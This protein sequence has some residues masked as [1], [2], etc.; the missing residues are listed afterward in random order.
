MRLIFSCWT[1]YLQKNK[2]FSRSNWFYF[3][4]KTVS[5]SSIYCFPRYI[6]IRN[7]YKAIPK[8]PRLGQN[9][10][11]QFIF[12]EGRGNYNNCRIV[13]IGLRTFWSP[14]DWR[15]YLKHDLCGN[16]LTQNKILKLDLPIYVIR[17]IIPNFIF[18]PFSSDTFFVDTRVQAYTIRCIRLVANPGAYL[19]PVA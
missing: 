11:L 16:R 18:P 7:Y 3:L 1:R 2:I 6:F 5:T 8:S 13:I 9:L 10:F 19:F 12:F 14:V 17:L 15:T 4:F